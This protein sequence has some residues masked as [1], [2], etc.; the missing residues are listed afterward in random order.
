MTA[1]PPTS[2]GALRHRRKGNDVQVVFSGGGTAGHFHPARNIAEA[3]GDI[4]PGA[5]PWFIGCE[6]RIEARELPALGYDYRL[7]PVAGLSTLRSS[8]PLAATIA[9]LRALAL[10]ALAVCRLLPELHKRAVQAA[11]L[12]GGYACAP[13]GIAARILGIPVVLQEQNTHPGRT[14]RLL[15]RWARQ[16]HVASPEARNALPTTVQNRV[17]DSGNPILPLPPVP[18]PAAARRALDLPVHGSVVLV[19]GGSQGARGLNR[20]VLEVL[21]EGLPTDDHF[22]FW[23][24]GPGHHDAVV[25]MLG[26]SAGRS[27]RA[28]PWLDPAAMYQA[29]A[30]AD[31][32][33]SRA[34]AM[35]T[36]EF[37]AWGLPAI[38]VPLPTAA[39]DHQT[40]NARALEAAGAALHLPEADPAGRPM[41]GAELW[42]EVG[43]L[44]ADSDRL[45][46]MA[47]SAR[48]RSRPDAA[49]T[50]AAAVAELLA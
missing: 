46:A 20:A 37:L 48:T 25:E 10:L 28:V 18:A 38:L 17:H 19:V 42:R 29:L 9:N 12:T 6:G 2:R 14:T 31:L 39:A 44:L 8:G 32:V 4:V 40:V 15:A 50:I 16:I 26:R 1:N 47:R 35:A 23:I 21:R 41:T 22:V 7:L 45:A 13:A 5:K 3:L 43:A 49:R 36:S 24:T 33:V 30:A 34:G 27:F 11:V